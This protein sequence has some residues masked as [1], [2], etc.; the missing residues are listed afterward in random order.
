MAA[1]TIL[2][3]CRTLGSVDC[4]LRSRQ[5][6]FD[7]ADKSADNSIPLVLVFVS[8]IRFTRDDVWSFG[9]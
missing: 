8:G 1:N 5:H 9:V 7:I 4:W 3:N 2:T 6:H